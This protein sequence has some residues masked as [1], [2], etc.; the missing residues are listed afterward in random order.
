MAKLKLDL[1]DI[2]NRGDQIE[3]GVSRLGENPKA[4]GRKSRGQLQARENQC[5]CY[6]GGRCPLFLSAGF[7]RW[8]SHRRQSGCSFQFT[9][10][11]QPGSIPED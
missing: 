6:G 11:G 4:A 8:H 2:Y 1:H 9:R 7:V 5:G 3:A 10:C